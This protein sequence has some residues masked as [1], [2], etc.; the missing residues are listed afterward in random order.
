MRTA[1]PRILFGLVVV[2]V[3]AGALTVVNLRFTRV[4]P[5]GNDFLPRW[6]GTRMFITERYSPYSAETTAAIQ[7]RM[8]GRNAEEGEDEALFAYP[9]YSMLLFAPF[10]LVEDYPLAR[11]LW[12]TA[13]EI[14]I[15]AL[16]LAGL[17]ATGWRPSRG[18]L[19]ALLLFALI[20]FHSAKPL[21]DGNAAVLVALFVSL[22]VLAMRRNRDGLAGM[23]FALSTI[24][25]QMVLLVLV[26]TLAWAL[27]HKRR[28]LV[29]SF[30]VSLLAL[31]G[32]S[33][34]LQPDWAAQNLA[35]VVAYGSYAPPGTLISILDTWWGQTG[36]TV[37]LVLSALLGL[38][39]FFEWGSAMRQRFD[40]FM[41][42]VCL[43]LVLGPFVGMPSTSSNHVIL[44]IVVMWLLAW[45]QRRTGQP[46][47]VW[48]LLPILFVG[49]WALFL[50]TLGEGDG[51]FREHLSL[52][53]ATPLFLLANLYWLRWW[54]LRPGGVS[55]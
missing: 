9:F 13:Q 8:Y 53:L 45:W 3:L 22:G 5:G 52:L 21:V 19:V 29:G 43:T 28:S 48:V 16:V 41:W 37:G 10:A 12:I 14:A 4:S 44:L 2:A 17:G 50:L 25:P 18:P 6:M 23:A 24:K 27:S 1:W 46:R 30:I 36:H 35:Q 38:L 26:F 47:A 33:F 42:A 39:L 54:L 31:I 40:W 34:A 20:W 32:A 49:V 11:A 51:Q 15:A 7:D 55:V